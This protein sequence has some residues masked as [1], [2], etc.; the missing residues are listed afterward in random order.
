ML[1]ALIFCIYT[2]PI[3]YFIAEIVGR[4]LKIETF[5]KAIQPV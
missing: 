4:S 2:I 3:G 1:Y 5:Q